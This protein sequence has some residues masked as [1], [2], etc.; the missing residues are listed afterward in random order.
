MEK[1]FAERA[2]TGINWWELIGPTEE[3]KVLHP[4]LQAMSAREL[5]V[6][7]CRGVS[8]PEATPRCVK[9]GPL[10]LEVIWCGLCFCPQ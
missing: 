3:L 10:L 8:F 2:R 1:R 6:L 5:D 7:A 4:G 9:L